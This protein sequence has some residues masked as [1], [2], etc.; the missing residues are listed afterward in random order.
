R[1]KS[2]RRA[3]ADPFDC[4]QRSV[5]TESSPSARV[6]SAAPQPHGRPPDHGSG[7]AVD[8]AQGWMGCARA[9]TMGIGMWGRR[10]F[11]VRRI[12][13]YGAVVLAL[14]TA[15]AAAARATA[16]SYSR[17]VGRFATA[18][19]SPVDAERGPDGNWYVMDEGLECVKVYAPD[20]KTVLRTVFTC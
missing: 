14:V 2:H 12:A 6:L 5:L 10:R 9:S 18:E 11:A 1:T 8:Q 4:R 16:P 7:F 17:D 19:I 20:L 3:C 13:L 15:A